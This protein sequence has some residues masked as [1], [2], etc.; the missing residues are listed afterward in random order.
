L[1]LEFRVSSRT[2]I[3]TPEPPK[4]VSPLIEGMPEE[5]RVSIPKLRELKGLV[6]GNPDLELVAARVE[7]IELLLEGIAELYAAA[8]EDARQA[9][10][11]KVAEMRC[12][13]RD[14]LLCI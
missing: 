10:E 3:D 14:T 13:L 11:A 6:R 4:G 1:K 9:A 2:V 8:T 5:I 7:Q 12:K